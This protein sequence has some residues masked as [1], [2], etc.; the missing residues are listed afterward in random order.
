MPTQDA[1][2]ESPVSYLPP[3][4]HVCPTDQWVL[5]YLPRQ[6]QNTGSSRGEGKVALNVSLQTGQGASAEIYEW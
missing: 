6:G 5:C 4:K 3:C 1:G 2:K